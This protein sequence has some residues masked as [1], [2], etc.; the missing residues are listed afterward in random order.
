MRMT[1]TCAG[2]VVGLN[3]VFY[4]L[5]ASYFD[6]HR[7]IITG[8]GSVSSY[9]PAQMTTVRISFAVLS[10]IVAAGLF[11]AWLRP[12]LIGHL[13]PVL[14]GITLVVAGL[15]VA[16]TELPR[17]LSAFCLVSGAVMLVLTWS[18]FRHRT[19]PAWAFLVAMCGVFAI[20]GVF[21]APR[22]AHALDVSLWIALIFSGLNVVA[23]I[24]L[25]SLN[26]EY[27]DAKTAAA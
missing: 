3:I 21:G 17:V 10:V 15:K 14:F 24:A 27:I 12:R 8:V 1:A 5:S 26:S 23:A 9:S 7:E 2:A 18:S 16:A 6:S 19:R 22:V 13:L 20:F 25:A 4:I 11:A